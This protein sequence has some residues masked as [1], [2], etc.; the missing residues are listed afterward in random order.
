MNYMRPIDENTPK[1]RQILLGYR[2]YATI[3]LGRWDNT[4]GEFLPRCRPDNKAP[5]TTHERPDSWC[6]LPGW[7]RPKPTLVS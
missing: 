5:K 4:Q 6:E 1:D 3:W 7:D 2:D